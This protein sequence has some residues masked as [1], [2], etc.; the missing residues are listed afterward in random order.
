MP[1]LKQL[2]LIVEY[3]SGYW[4]VDLPDLARAHEDALAS[5]SPKTKKD[6]MTTTNTVAVQ[7]ETKTFIYG[8]DAVNL[9]DVQIF[10][11]I[12][13]LEAAAKRWDGIVNKPKKLGAM[14]ET[15]HA[16]IKAL[17][18]YVDSRAAA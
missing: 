1:K 7:T 11:K 12:E 14:I 8:Q 3:P 13:K 18:E 2:K 4:C 6:T 17:V 10:D 5:T 16:D 9:T 15:I